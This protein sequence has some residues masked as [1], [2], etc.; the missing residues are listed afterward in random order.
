VEKIPK[1]IAI[2]SFLAIGAVLVGGYVGTKTSLD[3][4]VKDTAKQLAANVASAVQKT[5]PQE[6]RGI[7]IHPM[8]D[9]GPIEAKA[10]LVYDIKDG[11]ILYEKNAHSKLPL[12]SITKLMTGLVASKQLS[13][14]DVVVVAPEALAQEGDSSL[15]SKEEWRFKDLLDF[16]LI[17]SS[18]D[19]AAAIARTVG[20]KVRG[21][22]E[23]PRTAFVRLMNEKAH[24]LNL[25]DTQ[26]IDETGLDT[27]ADTAGAYGSAYDVA[28]LL[29]HIVK[30]N[31]EL[32]EATSHQSETFTSLSGIAHAARN[33]DE[34]APEIPALIGGK[35]GYTDLAGGNLAIVFDRSIGDPVAVVVL[36]S[37]KESRFTDVKA[38]VNAL[39][40]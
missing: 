4:A 25:Q 32:I 13:D 29:A 19:G 11:V 12:A 22:S 10:A 9:P 5:P 33:T 2:Y 28:R 8:K 36:G 3:V 40:K 16:T 17:T 35:T 23:G 34:A 30:T 7:T 27:G 14:D 39:E 1:Y 24:V 26:F 38:L 20:E 21:A 6:D 31:P 18:N 15:L 37:T